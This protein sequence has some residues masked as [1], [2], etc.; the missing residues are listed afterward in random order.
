[1][2]IWSSSAL[3]GSE[4]A[5][6][7]RTYFFSGAVLAYAIISAYAWAGFPYD[8][9]CS[10]DNPITYNGPAGPINVEFGNGTMG[11]ITLGQNSTF[12][13]CDQRWRGFDGFLF[14]PTANKQ[15]DGARWMTDS[16][17]TLTNI[18]GYT[19]LAFLVGFIILFFGN[20]IKNYIKSWMMGVCT[21][22]LSPLL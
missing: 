1:M 2:R 6:F 7:S 14:P 9:V 22:K 18:Y 10:P 21:Y 15:P 3:L 12:V 5:K 8:N 19:S 11:S 16:Q 4:V 13:F 20:A 17:E